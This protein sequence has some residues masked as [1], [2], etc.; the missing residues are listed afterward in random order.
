[1]G[2]DLRQTS[3]ARRPVPTTA[4]DVFLRAHAR[5]EWEELI[6]QINGVVE[7]EERLDGLDDGP[8]RDAFEKE[9]EAAV[10]RLTVLIFSDWLCDEHGTPPDQQTF[11][12]IET[13]LGMQAAD[14]YIK[15]VTETIAKM[16]K[17]AQRPKR[18]RRRSK[19]GS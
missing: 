9:H 5:Q 6:D 16:G 17:Q 12:Q 4:P 15:L 1:M 13:E 19:R 3:V 7:G 11:E 18:R 10:E 14:G 2:F 8:E